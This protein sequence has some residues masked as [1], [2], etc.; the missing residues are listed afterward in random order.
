MVTH[1][2]G[3]HCGAIR[4]EV[5]AEPDIVAHDCNCSICSKCCY[6]HLIVPARD[7]RLICGDEYLVQYQ[8]NSRT[9]RHMFCACCGIKSFYVPRSHPQGVSVNVRCLEH[10][11]IA[12]MKLVAF[13]GKNWE[14]SIGE[15]TDQ[16][17]S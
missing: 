9:A 16:E 17:P 1:I 11:T 13:D 5:D 8:F 3:C 4:F 7:F 12:S 6:Q 10:S 2:G 15:I 14:Q